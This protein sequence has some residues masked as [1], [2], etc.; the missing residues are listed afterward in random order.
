MKVLLI[1]V[2]YMLSFIS[3]P[4]ALYTIVPVCQKTSLFYTL[5]LLLFNLVKLYQVIKLPKYL[6]A[7][8]NI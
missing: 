5:L 4:F 2:L 8:F 3:Q 7:K 6:S 1:K